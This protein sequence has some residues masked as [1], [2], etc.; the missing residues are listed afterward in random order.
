MAGRELPNNALWNVE[1]VE[2]HLRKVDGLVREAL[3]VLREASARGRRL[4][5]VLIVASVADAREGLA[6]VPAEVA[7]A[8]GRLRDARAGEWRGKG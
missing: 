1:E 2:A 8:L 7:R 5:D 6:L 4:Q 3:E